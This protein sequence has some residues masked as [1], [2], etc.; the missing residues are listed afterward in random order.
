MHA[1]AI[2]CVTLFSVG[3][4]PQV[5]QQKDPRTRRV[6]TEVRHELM[7]LPY[8]GIFDNLAFRV[9]P[10]GVVRLLGQVIR[11]TLKSDA[12]GRLKGIPGVERVINDIE[13]LPV[14]PNDDR[15]R[16]DIARNIYRTETL[17]RYGFQVNPSIH[18]I[19][20]NGNVVLEGVVDSEADKTVAGLKAREVGGVF[21]VKNN[22][23]VDR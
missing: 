4:T 1:A 2:L 21:D 9:E 14:S 17:E 5:V 20:K 10:G 11:P 16:L 3:V 7:T 15:I 13:V 19:V 6:E 23:A 18:I 8:Y 12:E 22:L